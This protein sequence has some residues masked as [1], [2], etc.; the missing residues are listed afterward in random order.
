METLRLLLLSL[1]VGSTVSTAVLPA[2]SVVAPAAAVQE[3][4]QEEASVFPTFAPA[5]PRSYA[6][7]TA[8]TPTPQVIYITSTPQIIYVTPEPTPQV[9][10]VTPDPTAAPTAKPARTIYTGTSINR[11]LSR[12]MSG[13][14][15]SMLQRLLKDLGYSVGSVDGTFGAQTRSAVMSFQRNNGLKADGIA[16]ART[17][18]RL[19]SS[20]AVRGD[21]VSSSSSRKQLSYGMS[22]SDVLHLQQWLS[23]YGYYHGSFTGNYLSM[24]RAAVRWFQQ[25]NRL[26]VDGIAGPATLGLLYSGTALRAGAVATPAPTAVPYSRSLYRGLSGTDV[27]RLQNE[28]K[29]LGYF[30]G[31]ATGY[32]G[33]QTE[34]SV[35]EF[36]RCNGLYADG[37]AGPSTLS[38]LSSGVYYPGP[39]YATQA[40][41]AAPTQAPT[42]APTAVI[43]TA[44]PANPCSH[45]GQSLSSGNHG[46]AACGTS[47]HWA[48]DGR[49]HGAAPCGRSGHTLCGEGAHGIAE[50]GISGHYLCDG[51]THTA[52]SCGIAGHTVCDSRASHGAAACG[53]SGHTVCDGKDHTAASCGIAGHL[54]CDGADHGPAA[55]KTDGHYAC[56]GSHGIA[57]CGNPYHFICDPWTHNAAPC[58]VPGHTVCDG[59][60]HVAAPCGLPGH[61]AC[62]GDHSACTSVE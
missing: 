22:G 16:G 49:V 15:V 34:W 55:C 14:D 29:S 10:Y 31:N 59:K 23:A 36:Q 28:L 56:S 30:T 40:P 1:L 12:G 58:G 13:Q 26:S 38:K 50:C 6:V 46:A 54:K 44:A 32:F 9:I 37:I 33:S 19:V 25:V 11:E 17:I 2:Q 39:G 48:C 42:A 27:T 41:T 61:Y 47:G 52:A 21:T 20:S 45:C 53:I 5:A 18:R 35:R 60:T 8:P 7:R 3:V 62:S 57:A 51:F 24:T 43:P 4:Q